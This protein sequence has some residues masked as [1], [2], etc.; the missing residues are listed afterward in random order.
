[1]YLCNRKREKKPKVKTTH[2]T[3]RPGRAPKKMK[4]N[5]KT[6]KV[7]VKSNRYQMTIESIT[8]EDEIQALLFIEASIDQDIDNDEYDDN[9]YYLNGELMTD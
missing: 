4:T 1:M 9:D 8:F 2:K 3:P 7:E 6:W 5:N